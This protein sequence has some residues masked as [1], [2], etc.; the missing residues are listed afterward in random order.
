MAAGAF[1]E[2]LSEA[3]V[4]IREN[5]GRSSLQAI[6]VILG[7]ASV[8]GGFSISDSQRK[9]SD[10]RW[11]KL[12]GMDRLVVQQATAV[13]DGTPT[14][15]QMANLGLR[16]ED[17]EEGGA[18]E[19]KGVEGATQ[20]KGARAR[21][22][23]GYADQDRS[24]RGIDGDYLPLNG[25]SLESGRAFSAE[26]FSE[27]RPV[28]LLG[29]EA[30]ATFFPT[31][32][33]VG[34]TLRIG[35]I[36]VVVVGTLSEKVFRWREGEPNRF[37]WR[38]RVIMVPSALVARR[39]NGDRWNR[40][41][42]VSFRIRDLSVMK[43]FSEGLETLLRGNH[44]LQED[45][46]ID[47]IAARVR[48]RRSQGDVYNL[49]FMLSGI[50]SLVGGGMVNVNIQMATLK[51]RVREV[52]VKMA[53]GASGREIFKGFMTEALLVT[54]LGSV[55]GLLG[56]VAFSKII[57]SFLKIPLY[58]QPLSFVWAFFLA[59]AF[60]FVF[61]LYPAWKASRLSPME[62]LRYE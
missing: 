27:G 60:G 5:L 53:I 32:E 46:R 20:E 33:A 48:K 38:N 49:I 58:M 54:G 35:D 36:P 8:L 52:G 45:Y 4:E 23:S 18:L 13:K 22:R 25:Y 19:P 34:Q 29:A 16:S 44:R 15:L 62:A 11:M 59:S 6:G 56:G 17:R 21:V 26:E 40:A 55:V 28:A 3:W 57:T 12:G 61:A 51:D 37:A 31:G 1:R 7:V 50:L 30:R 2:R 24:V 39:M 9:R 42:R 14:A 43:T 10:E 41:D 47:D